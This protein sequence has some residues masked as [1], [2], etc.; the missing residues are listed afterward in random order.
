MFEKSGDQDGE[1]LLYP[2]VHEPHGA[3]E[4]VM[5]DMELLSKIGKV[6]YYKPL[7]WGILG[8]IHCTLA[9]CRGFHT[10]SNLFK[11]CLGTGYQHAQKTPLL[12]S[13]KAVS[14]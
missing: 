10:C 14:S 1:P 5:Y 12:P 2:L 3:V 11:L 4:A 13:F 7:G 6:G 8:N 9:T